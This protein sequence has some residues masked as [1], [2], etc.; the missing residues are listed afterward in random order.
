MKIDRGLI[1]AAGVAVAASA[2]ASAAAGGG[3]GAAAPEAAAA[4]ALPQVQCASGA[5][6]VTAF[7]TAS[8]AALNRTLVIRGEAA[9]A[10]YTTAQEQARQGIASDPNNP[11]HYYLLGQAALSTNNYLA[12]DSAFRRTVQLCPQFAGEVDPLRLRA[13]QT[14]FNTG[15]EAFNRQDTAA[16]LAQWSTAATLYDRFPQASFNQAV[17]YAG[18]NDAARA[19]AAYRTTLA[20]LERTPADTATAAEMAEMRASS[21]S[22]LVGVGAQLFAANQFAQAAEIFNEVHRAD[23]NNRDAWY[24]HALS[25]YKLERWQDLVPVATRLVQIDPLN[26]N[27]RIILFN[28]YKGLSDAAKTARNTAVETT[29][30]Q[31]ALSTLTAADALPVQINELQLTTL[32][33]GARLAGT[34]TGA[35]AAAGTP[36]RLE[37]TFFGP[38][39]PVGTQTVTV[40]APAK[41]A[42][43]PIEV[44][45][46]TTSP[47]TGWSYRVAS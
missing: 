21:M 43:T 27:G 8:Q 17:V 36:V 7:A 14:V 10:F 42:T 19:A 1:L 40:N 38:T 20:A 34:V 16:A 39:G 9:N 23:P 15:V 26:Y 29:N 24:N 33:G 46:N 35:T 45:L 5:P 2:C 11:L 25:L 28:A 37:F 4:S 32:E 30:R 41:S 22:G 31:L 3:A 18:R 12:A 6:T 47:V 44:R 13:A